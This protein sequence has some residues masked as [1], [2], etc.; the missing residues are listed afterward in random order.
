MYKQINSNKRR[1]K[2]LV[3]MFFLFIVVLGYTIGY[4]NNNIYVWTIIATIFSFVSVSTSYFSGD[5]IALL[6]SGAKKIERKDN[7]QLYRLVENLCITANLPV[8][9]IYIIE[10]NA[11]NAFATGRDPKHASIAFTTGILNT[12]EKVELEGVIAH[13]LSHVKNYDILLATII[14]ALVGVVIIISDMLRYSSRSRIFS[15]KNNN[16]SNNSNLIVMI[17]GIVLTIFAPIIAKIIQLAISRQ[18]EY[19]ADADAALL[20]RFPEG[21]AKALKKIS[22]SPTKLKRTSL[23]TSHLYIANPISSKKTFKNLFSTHPD[24]NDRI[25]RLNRMANLH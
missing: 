6:S 25:D 2:I 5:K 8:P 17:V 19:L 22:S 7:P 13:E 10:D 1:T 18:R 16:S 9:K 12:L 11:P 23:A 20:T 15:S 24:I 4:V 3:L 21:L 14:I